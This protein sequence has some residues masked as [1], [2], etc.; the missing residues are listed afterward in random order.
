MAASIVEP[1]CGG[2]LLLVL[3]LDSAGA[4]AEAACEGLV[5]ATGASMLASSVTE[6]GGW[7]ASGCVSGSAA[8]A[9]VPA[10]V[11]TMSMAGKDAGAVAAASVVSAPTA[12]A[13]T[14]A[15]SACA[16]A[17]SSAPSVAAEGASVIVVSAPVGASVMV[18]S[19][20]VGASGGGIPAT[21][22]GPARIPGPKGFAEVSSFAAVVVVDVVDGGSFWPLFLRTPRLPRLVAGGAAVESG[23]AGR[24]RSCII[25]GGVCSRQGVRS[26]VFLAS[27][28]GARG[29]VQ[30]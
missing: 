11:F 8:G 3:L 7:S 6:P 25:G 17:G 26:V 23:G 10:V 5:A 30:G 24:L 16:I 21:G 18:V 15:S 13:A 14:G 12:T 19:V 20:T 28:R 1:I 22:A 29:D 27:L 2:P 9:N 4:G